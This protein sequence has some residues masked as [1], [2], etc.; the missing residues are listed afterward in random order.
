[1]LGDTKQFKVARYLAHDTEHVTIAESHPD[2][3]GRTSIGVTWNPQTGRPRGYPNSRGYQQWFI[4]P[5]EIAGLVVDN[6]KSLAKAIGKP[7]KG[8]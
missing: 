1:M 7:P 3:H 2:L 8:K 6:E 4:L 5:D